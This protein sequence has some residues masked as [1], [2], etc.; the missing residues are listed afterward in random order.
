V[1]A[2]QSTLIYVAYRLVETELPHHG[3]D[4]LIQ[5]ALVGF[6]NTFWVGIGPKLI[7]FPLMAECFRSVARI[8]CN[9]EE[10]RP[11]QTIVFWALLMGRIS[12]LSEVDDLW[13]LPRLKTLAK[14]LELRTWREASDALHAF[15][16]VKALHDALGEAV[17]N[18]T[19]AQPLPLEWTEAAHDFTGGLLL[20]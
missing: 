3:F 20:L 8:I 14:A 11:R 7:T 16:W 18:A 6:Q 5:L 1:L 12:L 17:W 4:K 9:G 15:P 19:L 10:T 2:F 13:L